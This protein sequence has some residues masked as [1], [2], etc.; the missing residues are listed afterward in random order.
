MKN[1][2]TKAYIHALTA[3]NDLKDRVRGA[4]SNI[5]GE[6]FVESAVKILIAIVI[7]ALLL[8]GLY[9]LF[10]EIILPTLNDRVEEMFDYAG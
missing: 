8:A 6:N 10:D 9:F 3:K 4:L 7:G 5:R 2:M 1:L